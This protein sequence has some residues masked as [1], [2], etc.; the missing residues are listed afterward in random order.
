MR[1]DYGN[2]CSVPL[3]DGYCLVATANDV[4]GYKEIY[5]DLHDPS[6]N[7]CQSLAIVGEEYFYDSD[8]DVRDEVKPVHGSYTVKVYSDPKIDD[9]IQDFAVRRRSDLAEEMER[10]AAKL[11]EYIRLIDEADSKE[12]IKEITFKAFLEDDDAVS[13]KRTLYNKVVTHA[14]KR[15][16]Q[17]EGG[18]L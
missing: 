8:C 15:E 11:L 16:A 7:Y 18:A 5:I 9:F 1:S 3:D 14:V 2:M 13:S 17:L 10:E 4:D 6:G 12:R